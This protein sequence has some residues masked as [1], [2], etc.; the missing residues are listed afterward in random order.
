MFEVKKEISDFSYIVLFRSAIWG[1]KIKAGPGKD[2]NSMDDLVK[3]PQLSLQES[4]ENELRNRHMSSTA[5]DNAILNPTSAEKSD[6]VDSKVYLFGYL[7]EMDTKSPATLSNVTMLSCASQSVYAH[8][9]TFKFC[10]KLKSFIEELA[11][12]STS[13][14]IQDFKEQF[15]QARKLDAQGNKIDKLK[16]YLGSTA[17]YLMKNYNLLKSRG[18]DSDMSDD[19]SFSSSKISLNADIENRETPSFD[20][21]NYVDF[22][23]NSREILKMPVEYEPNLSEVS[24]KLNWEFMSLT[25]LPIFFGI[26]FVP[27]DGSISYSTYPYERTDSGSW[28]I[29]PFSSVSAYAQPGFGKILIQDFPSGKFVVTFDNFTTSK[30]ATRQLTT[31]CW[32]SYSSTLSNDIGS[33][34]IS[35]KYQRPLSECH[36]EFTIPRKTILVVPI[37]FHLICPNFQDKKIQLMWNLDT[38]GNDIFF[39]I[40]YQQKKSES[41]IEGLPAG[42]DNREESSACSTETN[43]SVKKGAETSQ[44]K[45]SKF[46]GKAK[47]VIKEVKTVINQPASTSSSDPGVRSL[48]SRINAVVAKSEMASRKIMKAMAGDSTQNLDHIFLESSL[49][50]KSH[51]NALMIFPHGKINSTEQLFQ[52]ILEISNNPGCYFFLLENSQVLAS[53]KQITCSISII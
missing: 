11:S 27:T 35:Q 13:L 2:I 1:E 26:E 47:D 33:P 24:A 30:R 14:S 43:S 50:F 40:F 46:L 15:S 17:G 9:G 45:I 16:S 41:N 10:T 31:R 28:I 19:E 5:V 37:P 12:L 3:N 20:D 25:E 51:Q 6:V 32:I 7:V 18:S 39:T 48:S 44:V 29:F 38:G 34:T 4:T 21:E 36:F 8:L 22:K 49:F 52:G 53:P 42:E 23:I